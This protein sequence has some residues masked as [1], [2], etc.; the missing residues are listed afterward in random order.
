MNHTYK[1]KINKLS[2]DRKLATVI[3]LCG[4]GGLFFASIIGKGLGLSLVFFLSG[5]IYLVIS[6]VNSENRLRHYVF[7]K[8]K[9]TTIHIISIVCLILFFVFSVFYLRYARPIEYFVCASILSTILGFEVLVLPKEKPKLLLFS[10]LIQIILLSAGLRWGVFF[11]SPG[12]VGTDAWAHSYLTKYILENSHV[13]SPNFLLPWNPIA[14][15]LT[16]YASFPIMHL[17]W[18]IFSLITAIPSLKWDL[19]LSV[20]ISQIFSLLFVFLLSRKV[21][22]D[23]RLALFA[24]LFVGISNWEIVFGTYM[25]PNTLGLTFFTMALY[26]LI[27]QITEGTRSNLVL[28]IFT[29]FVIILTH[30]LSSFV[31]LVV[32]F[33]LLLSFYLIRALNRMTDFSLKNLFSTRTR[34]FEIP[35]YVLLVA[36]SILAYWMLG[37]DFLAHRTLS[38]ELNISSIGYV[39]SPLFKSYLHYEFDQLGIY[40]LYVFCIFGS[41]VC[42]RNREKYR[43]GIVIILMVLSLFIITYGS[44][45][46]GFNAI[47][48]ERW[49]AFDFILISIPA[50]LGLANLVM[51]RK[52]SVILLCVLLFSLTFLMIT[53]GDA[54]RDSPLIQ[55]EEVAGISYLPSELQAAD[56]VNKSFSG[57]I[58]T[59]TNFQDYFSFA[60]RRNT[61]SI[62]FS[63]ITPPPG[64]LLLERNYIYERP[65]SV[66]PFGPLTRVNVTFH[67]YL[68]NKMDKIYSNG[69][70]SSYFSYSK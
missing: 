16:E 21:I 63:E 58:F 3:S 40:L 17:I 14:T 27:K 67:E 29:T 6:K 66:Q 42:I 23:V 4:A 28:L 56:W 30:T 50:S 37:S 60:L 70:V 18:A 10:I 51:N 31:F 59:D 62:N 52:G 9:L 39:A 34:S 38:L 47:L 53:T 43:L 15:Q 19:A 57:A 49:M 45:M 48:P 22:A 61:F 25:I 26:L 55:K 69:E 7:A 46:I 24:T 65:T 68:N 5:L 36:V 13:I 32:A 12:F 8:S 20:G 54:N 41:L 64:S 1:L 11:E 35:L 44:W 2:F 33:L